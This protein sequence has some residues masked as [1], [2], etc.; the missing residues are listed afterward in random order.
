MLR[1]L[2]A[3]ADPKVVVGLVLF[4][5]SVLILAAATGGP[6]GQALAAVL[7]V[8]VVVLALMLIFCY[9]I[10]RMNEDIG[11]NRREIDPDFEEALEEYEDG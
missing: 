5:V 6:A 10:K 3:L 11:T 7:A 1:K 2:T 8:L 9:W 4:G